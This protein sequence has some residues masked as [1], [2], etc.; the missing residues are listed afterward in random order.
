MKAVK[1]SASFLQGQVTAPPSKSV[2]H[3][4]LICAALSGGRCTV[5][6][7]AFSNDIHATLSVLEQLGARFRLAKGEVE[8][9]G[10]SP[11][12]H[13]VSLDCGESGS[14]L[15]FLRNHLG[16]DRN[17]PSARTAHRALSGSFQRT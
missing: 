1:V 5:E 17:R 10:F 9:T 15:R 11:A 4:A 16:S 12:P 8:F 7:I 6:N 2:A 3:R 13:G 14:T